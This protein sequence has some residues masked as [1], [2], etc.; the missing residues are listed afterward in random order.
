MMTVHTAKGLEFPV[1][2]LAGMEDGLF[3]LARAFDDPEVL[4]E[5]RRLLY[6]AV[7]RAG[8][9]LHVSWA[10]Q[11]LR[12]GER[13]PSKLS[14]FLDR[15]EAGLVEPRETPRMASEG[16]LLGWSAAPSARR[17]G[18][19]VRR[20][21]M[22]DDEPAV[23]QDQPRYVKGERVRHKTFGSGTI[24]E[25][26]GAGRDTKVVVDF[27]DETIGRKKLVVAFAGLERGID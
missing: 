25:L 22:D 10:R 9:A 4:E 24:A 15:L 13:L 8:D 20:D 16:R 21:W 7:T 6:V 11:R 18:A 23:S 2:H 14:S 26:S 19:P 3:P 12:N 17:P 27:D 5:E 1:V